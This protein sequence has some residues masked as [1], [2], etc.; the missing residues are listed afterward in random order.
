MIFLLE[1]RTKSQDY[2]NSRFDYV[3]FDYVDFQFNSRFQI[4]N[5]QIKNS[6]FHLLIFLYPA[7]CSKF[8][9]LNLLI[10]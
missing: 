1:S 9:S 10:L 2:R 5:H 3:D 8:F 4:Q 6:P 7:Q